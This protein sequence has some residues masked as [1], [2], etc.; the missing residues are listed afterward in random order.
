MNVTLQASGHNVAYVIL[1]HHNN[2]S[3]SLLGSLLFERVRLTVG[4]GSSS[5]N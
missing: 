2:S 5:L 1:Q 3:N 4:V